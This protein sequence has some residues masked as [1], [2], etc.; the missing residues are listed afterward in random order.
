MKSRK[1]QNWISTLAFVLVFLAGLSLMLYPTVSNYWNEKLQSQ[2]IVEYDNSM[3][4][5]DPETYEIKMTEA[6]IFNASLAT[7]SNPYLLTPEQR[8]VYPKMLQ[9]SENSAPMAYIEIP[10]IGV[11][12]PIY[13]GTDE[14]TLKTA[15]GHMEWTSLPIGGE[16]THCVIS[17]HRGLPSAELMTNI[18]QMEK[19]DVFYIHVLGDTLK[20]RVD[21]I[22]VVL[23]DDMKDVLISE[24]KDYVT[25]VTCTPYGI[26]S[27]RLLVRGERVPDTA[28]AIEAADIPGEVEFIEPV[29]VAIALLAVGGILTVLVL[30]FSGGRKKKESVNEKIEEKT[31]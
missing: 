30:A 19:G 1:K 23:P 11:N 21:K 18:D 10:S 14:N 2:V 28:S 13:H 22:S 25:L 15:V 9:L 16:S 17:G 31:E 6:R 29:Y 7:R 24:S 8:E 4:A 5:I 12:L 26:N 27:H 3:N 20:Y